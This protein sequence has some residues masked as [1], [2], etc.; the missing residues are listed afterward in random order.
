MK[1]LIL[2]MISTAAMIRLGKVYENLMVDLMATSKKLR[3][4][5]KRVLMMIADVDYAEAVEALNQAGGSVKIALVMLLA[6]VEREE[7]ERRLQ[8][9]QGF[10]KEAIRDPEMFSKESSQR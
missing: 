3:E 10:V 8:K 2:N 1:K 7:A 4:R 5:S 9:V 6:G